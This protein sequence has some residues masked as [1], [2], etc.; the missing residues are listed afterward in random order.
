[1]QVAFDGCT[2][3]CISFGAP[4]TPRPPAFAPTVGV[5]KAGYLGVAFTVSHV[6][7]S[8]EPTWV[9]FCSRRGSIGP[10][11]PPPVLHVNHLRVC[12]SLGAGRSGVGAFPALPDNREARAP[13]VVH[14]RPPLWV[15]TLRNPVKEGPEPPSHSGIQFEF[16]WGRGWAQGVVPAPA[17]DNSHRPATDM[18]PLNIRPLC[19]LEDGSIADTLAQKKWLVPS[20]R[21]TEM[22]LWAPVFFAHPRPPAGRAA[23]GGGEARPSKL[24]KTFLP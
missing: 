11:L 1:M 14:F 5:I 8:P 10:P 18:S 13:T 19:Y 20:I 16:W 15:V 12:F 21:I 9:A 7:R 3:V 22:L 4:G 6:P 24:P 2:I 23:D 17:G